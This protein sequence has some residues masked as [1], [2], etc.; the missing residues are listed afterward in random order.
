MYM[1][2]LSKSTWHAVGEQIGSMLG[3]HQT[4][5]SRRQVKSSS[6]SANPHEEPEVNFNLLSDQRDVVRLLEGVKL[7]AR[8][9]HATKA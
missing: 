1:A 5:R 9:L 7:A 6:R 3:L 4:G 2:V 8:T